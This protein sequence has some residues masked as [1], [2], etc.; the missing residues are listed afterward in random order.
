MM[1]AA[2]CACYHAGMTELEFEKRVINMGNAT[3]YWT[4]DR[5]LW[6]LAKRA[7]KFLGPDWPNEDP[8]LPCK[9]M[10]IEAVYAELANSAGSN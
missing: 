10:I 7:K 6:L 2:R 3:N 4:K 8:R 1:S 5:T 9:A